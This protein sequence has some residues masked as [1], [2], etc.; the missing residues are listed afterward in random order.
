MLVE[1]SRVRYR[2]REWVAALAPAVWGVRR[3]SWL[4]LAVARETRLAMYPSS[5]L[6][7][8]TGTRQTGEGLAVGLVTS[9]RR[10]NGVGGKPS[11][12]ANVGV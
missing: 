8:D 11:H 6:G 1:G 12:G 5:Y 10:V 7:V 4:W 3:G 9:R 2:A